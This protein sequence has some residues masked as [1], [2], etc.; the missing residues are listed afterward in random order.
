MTIEMRGISKS[1]GAVEALKDVDFTAT[2]GEVMAIFGDNGA[3]KSTLI[4][5]L[6]G[7]IEPTSGTI[8][9]D[10]Q[11]KKFSNPLDAREAGIGTL[12]QDL[13]IFDGLDVTMN[14]YIG[15]EETTFG[16][17][18]D[19]GKMQRRTHE[20]VRKF[21]VRDID[22][23]A[24]LEGLSGGQRQIVAI[25]RTTGFG[26]DFVILDEPTSALS[27]SAAQEVLAV[28]RSLADSGIG[29]IVITHNVAQGLKVADKATVLRLGT[30]AGVRDAKSTSEEELVS[31]IVGTN[32]V[33]A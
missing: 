33:A 23:H 21:S 12:Y 9:V 14:F 2:R 26:G 16:G 6:S 4:K 31:L 18:M 25:T 27:P 22:I 20:L 11:E 32:Q 19:F 10:G 8:T 29:V 24:A 5:I 7:A 1:Y 17:F 15:R 3:G 30:V 13:A 28:V